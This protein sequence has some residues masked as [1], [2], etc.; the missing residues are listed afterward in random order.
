MSVQ[1]FKQSDKGKGKGHPILFGMPLAEH[2]GPFPEGGGYPLGF[3][4]RAYEILRVTA[5][6]R[7]LHVCSGSMLT[8]VRVDIRPSTNPTVVADVLHLP[9]RD[10]TFQWVMADPPYSREYAENLYG[11][12]EMYPDP[13][14]LCEECLRVLKPAGMLGFF[15]HIVPKF[16]KPG[17]LIKVY[18]ITQGIGYNIRAWSVLSKRAIL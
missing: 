8:G 7:V 15:H 14:Q 2:F 18:G 11:T 1:K 16:R 5:P 10:E 13:H 9:F 4:E 3:L 17:H 6:Q 12:G